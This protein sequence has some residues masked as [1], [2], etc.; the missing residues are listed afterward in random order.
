MVVK[1]IS[2]ILKNRLPNIFNPVGAIRPK[3]LLKDTL[4]GSAV[5]SSRETRPTHCFTASHIASRR[6][7]PVLWLVVSPLKSGSIDPIN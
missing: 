4:K 6:E 1:D 5:A 2:L 3:G 7:S